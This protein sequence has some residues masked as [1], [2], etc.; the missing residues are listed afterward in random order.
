MEERRL[1][2]TMTGE[3]LQPVRLYY[4]VLDL[5]Q[6][7]AS[8]SKM[9]CVELDRPNGRFV[10]L[11]RNESRQLTFSS[12][13]SSI[14][15]ERRPIVLGSIYFRQQ[16]EMLLDLRSFER[17]TKAIVFF[18]QYISRSAARV[19]HAAVVNRLFSDPEASASDAMKLFDTEPVVERNPDDFIESAKEWARGKSPEERLQTAMPFLKQ[20]TRQQLPEIEKFPVHFY[21]EGIASL[22][23]LLKIR[24]LVAFEH[25][26]GNND[27]TIAD[28]M[29]RIL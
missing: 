19:T 12:P 17:A 21:E 18:D 16:G 26:K 23:R 22:E 3:I 25:W 13:Y 9:R 1:L 7:Q 5:R 24:Q 27:F 2:S 6:T 20:L 29:N 15:R 10:W 28:L 4:E 8:L 11:Y 14:S